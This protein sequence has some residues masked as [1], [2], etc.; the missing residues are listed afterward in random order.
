MTAGGGCEC[1]AFRYEIDGDPKAVIVCH[2]THCQ[3]QSGSAFRMSMII[4]ADQFRP[5]QGTLKSF[6]RLADSGSSMNC[7]FCPECGNRIY[8][9]KTGGENVVILKPG[10]LDNPKAVMPSRH[11]WTSEKQNWIELTGLPASDRQPC[12]S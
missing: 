9:Q 12:K 3:R 5:L 1:G 4:V 7:H 10:T 2:C 6:S 8:N 11:L